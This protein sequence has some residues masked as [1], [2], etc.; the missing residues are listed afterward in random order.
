MVKKDLISVIIPTYNRDKL[1][2][3][4]VNSVLNQTY[5]NIEVII[6]DD[7]STD[8]TEKVIKKIKDKRIKYIKL[9]K[10]Y[11]SA[12][13]KNSYRNLYYFSRFR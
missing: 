10:N 7:G 9:D 5:D 11:G 3:D 6:V 8:K 4:S 1:I 12:Y 2:K 13:A